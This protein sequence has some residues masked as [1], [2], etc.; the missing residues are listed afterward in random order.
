[1]IDCTSVGNCVV[2]G[3]SGN[4]GGGFVG[5]LVNGALGPDEVVP[6]TEYLYGVGCAADGDCLLTGTSQ[7]GV[8]GYG[9]GVTI[10][11]IDDQAGAVTSVPK[12]SGLGQTECGAGIDDC[13]TVG[14]TT[15]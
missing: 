3:E 15:S 4:D 14:S 12:A 9:H 2:A 6:G 5:T 13:T 8:S 10:P 11:F 1:M 7:V